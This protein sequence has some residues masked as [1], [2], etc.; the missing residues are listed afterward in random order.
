MS[1]DCDVFPVVDHDDPGRVLYEERDSATADPDGGPFSTD[2]DRVGVGLV[3]G[4]IESGSVP[5]IRFTV[6]CGDDPAP[7]LMTP[8][9]TREDL[10]KV[11]GDFRY[12]VE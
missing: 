11:D 1:P 9:I 6:T 12:V 8:R 5:W 4:S 7:W 2:P 10:E 3:G